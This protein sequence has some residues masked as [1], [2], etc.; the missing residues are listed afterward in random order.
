MNKESLLHYCE[1]IDEVEETRLDIQRIKSDIR[2]IEKQLLDIENG[3]VVKDKVYGGE[4]GWQG[5][6][7]EGVPIP[8]Y[9]KLKIILGNRKICLE[10]EID[11]LSVRVTML[12]NEKIQVQEFINR[13]KDPQIRRIINFRCVRRM[14]WMEVARRMGAGYSE[15]AVRKAFARFLEKEIG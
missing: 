12:D 13:L 10:H 9:S 3:E 11:V 4:G 2:K 8:E 7:I 15:D 14:P 1:L 5:F 6:V